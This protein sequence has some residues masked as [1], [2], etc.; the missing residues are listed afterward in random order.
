MP[1]RETHVMDQRA[2][3]VE[4]VLKKRKP[5]LECCEQFGVSRKTAYKWLQRFYQGG[6][7]GLVDCSRRPHR[8]PFAVSEDV[9]G[10][11]VA[12]RKAHPLWGPR[13]LRAFLAQHE[14]E[15]SWPA[16]STIGDL[17]KRRGLV[18]G[19]RRR[20][21][22]PQATQPLAAAT[23][24]NVVWTVDFKGC[25]RVAGR[26]CHPLTI[27]DAQSRYLLRVQSL[28]GERFVPVQGVFESAFREFGLPLRIRSD[29]G[30]PF[31]SR[32]PGG[33][34]RLSVWW[35]RLGITPERIE[36]GH[37]EQNGRHERMH[38]T[39]KDATARP[40]RVSVEEQQRA[41]DA[42]RREFNDERP[43]EALGQRTP[44]SGYAPSRRRFPEEVPDPEYPSEFEVRRIY[45][46]SQVRWNF[47]KLMMSDVLA[48]Q[49]VGFEP[50]S[51]GRWQLWF[52]PIYLGLVIEE[53]KGKNSFIRCKPI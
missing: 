49:A 51:D 26:Y 14:P 52:G 40:P 5:L 12:A 7:P 37:P 8:N 36:P 20:L 39:L 41:F 33:L 53:G 27:A 16:P 10:L 46:N 25:F 50:V 23:E 18:E 47:A 31:A 19:R 3:F 45:P 30:S 48:N 4:E 17:L 9:A 34:S 11:I 24:P 15:T 32:G 38:R 13:K 35:V 21:R 1:W 29:N 6:M 44:A 43:H 28:D 2:M 22:T 42:F